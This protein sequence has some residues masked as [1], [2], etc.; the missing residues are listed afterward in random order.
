VLVLNGGGP[1][2][3][4][5]LQTSLDDWDFAY[6]AILR[7][8]LAIV[9]VA[10][11][12]MRAQKW[13]RIIALTSTAVKEP[14]PTLVLSSAFRSALVSALKTLA[15]EVAHEG[16]TINCIATGRIKTE[17]LRQLY[18]NDE[19]ALDEA[20]KCDIPIR[21]AGMP[22]EF[23]PMIAFLSGERAKYITGQTIAIDGGLIRSVY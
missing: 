12:H 21:R 9:N 5:Y 13:G 3:G 18:N 20:A 22:E 1:K 8:M 2:P 6:D 19:L 17:R 4:T 16:V 10:L 14:I 23:S 7:N 11:P 15:G